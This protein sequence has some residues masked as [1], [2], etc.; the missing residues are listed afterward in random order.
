[1]KICAKC[2]HRYMVMDLCEDHSYQR[3]FVLKLPPRFGWNT[4]FH[5]CYPLHPFVSLT[6]YEALLTNPFLF[7]AFTLILR[8]LHYHSL[9]GESSH[10]SQT[11]RGSSFAPSSFSAPSSQSSVEPLSCTIATTAAVSTLAS[12]VTA[13]RSSPSSVAAPQS[14][15]E[16]HPSLTRGSMAQLHRL[17]LFARSSEI[18][19]QH[20][21]LGSKLTHTRQQTGLRIR[22][23]HKMS[24]L[25]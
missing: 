25:L 24:K 11:S 13:G 18:G 12:A 3:C 8:V 10:D 15:L 5:N 20:R 19:S 23:V 14:N 22:D 6:V 7:S 16:H 21:Q 4:F 9:W 17:A 1:M 2:Q